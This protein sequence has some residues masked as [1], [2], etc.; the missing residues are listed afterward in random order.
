MKSFAPFLLCFGTFVMLSQAVIENN[1]A[2]LQSSSAERSRA[3]PLRHKTV[4]NND[5]FNTDSTFRFLLRILL[6]PFTIFTPEN[7]V[8]QRSLKMTFNMKN[9]TETQHKNIKQ[10]TTD[11]PEQ[12]TVLNSL[13]IEQKESEFQ[14]PKHRA[15]EHREVHK[16]SHKWIPFNSFPLIFHSALRRNENTK[17]TEQNNKEKKKA[18]EDAFA[19]NIFVGHRNS[20]M[21]KEA[22]TYTHLNKSVNNTNINFFQRRYALIWTIEW[23]SLVM[24]VV[25]VMIFALII[26][27]GLL[28]CQSLCN[29][30]VDVKRVKMYPTKLGY[31]KDAKLLDKHATGNM[32]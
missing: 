21:P 30:H 26:T 16:H 15:E 2:S 5:V 14:I 19:E 28:L 20:A 11:N 3:N 18:N 29:V 31:L 25:I 23:R 17:E 24:H 7:R 4:E 22:R 10:T 32:C 6:T 12:T 8:Y 27:L 1:P 13:F 9:S